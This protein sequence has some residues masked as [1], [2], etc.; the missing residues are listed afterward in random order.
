MLFAPWTQKSELTTKHFLPPLNHFIS[1]SKQITIIAYFSIQI[2]AEAVST[3]TAI[4]GITPDHIQPLVDAGAIPHIVKLFA[5]SPSNI[6]TEEARDKSANA[7][8]AIREWSVYF[9]SFAHKFNFH[10]YY[11]SEWH[12]QQQRSIFLHSE[13][14]DLVAWHANNF[15]GFAAP[16]CPGNKY[17]YML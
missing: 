12:L 13:A 8:Y 15:I 11:L 1:L 9:A 16:N 5:S 3:V 17:L 4:T 14:I 2:R 6:E 7:L 10:H